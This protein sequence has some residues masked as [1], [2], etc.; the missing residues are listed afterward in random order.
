MGRLID[1]NSTRGKVRGLDVGESIDFKDGDVRPSYLYKL[2][3]EM[4][5][6]Y[7]IRISVRKTDE[8][9]YRVTR[10]E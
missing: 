7:G 9:T 8:N 2:T 10:Y 1:K 3:S 6:D 4:H 5:G